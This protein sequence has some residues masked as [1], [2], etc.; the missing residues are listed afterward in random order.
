MRTDLP[1]G[2]DISGVAQTTKA[3]FVVSNAKLKTNIMEFSYA[4]LIVNSN[5]AVLF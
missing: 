4:S 1:K 2:V 5:S 3:C